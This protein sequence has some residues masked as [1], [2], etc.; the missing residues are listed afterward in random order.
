MFDKIVSNITYWQNIKRQNNQRMAT[1]TIY[2]IYLAIIFWP[3][4][5]GEENKYN[6]KIDNKFVVTHK[7][8]HRNSK[9]QIKNKT[10]IKIQEGS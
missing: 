2:F 4:Q 9:W 8:L 5:Q 1:I 6:G 10:S 3:I 7:W